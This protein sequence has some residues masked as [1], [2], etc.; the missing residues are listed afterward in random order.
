MPDPIYRAATRDEL[1][2]GVE[3]ARKENWNPGY[4]DADGYWATDPSGFVCME[5]SH[6]VVGF[7]S[8]V[9]FGGKFGFMGFYIVRP[10]YRGR[11]L[12]GPF[13][14]W[15]KARLMARLDP[16]ATI[17]MDGVPAM[18]SFYGRGGFVT[19]HY[20]V[21]MS[22]KAASATPNP[23]IKD[24]ALISW[25]EILKLDQ[26]GFSTNRETLLRY[27]IDLPE[28]FSFGYQSEGKLEGFGVIR[29][30]SDGFRIG[31]LFA[32]TA[33][34]AEKLLLSLCGAVSG[35]RVYVDM[36][37]INPEAIPMAKRLGMNE[38]SRC[39][40]MYAGPPPDIP[41]DKTFAVAS[42]ELG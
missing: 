14:R 19:N 29:P 22:G 21:R 16:G 2:I 15:R 39:A 20:N 23:N 18:E 10:D 7:G 32:E 6:E 3:W 28:S 17:G 26:Q 42:L 33:N 38:V 34:I 37:D 41:Y 12:G 25:D 8:V 11:G 30:A 5:I 24:L 35:E 36:P 1:N 40:R 4:K 13:W 9:S 27:W 31:P